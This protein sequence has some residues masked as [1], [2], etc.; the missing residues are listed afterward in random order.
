M[1]KQ[2]SFGRYYEVGKA[3]NVVTRKTI[4]DMYLSG[5][6][7]CAF[8]SKHCA[9]S[10]NT[11]R[12]VIDKYQLDGS[13]SPVKYQHG[14]TRLKSSEDIVQAI[15]YYKFRKPSIYG[16]EI[17]STL[18]S[19]GVTTNDRLPSLSTI[20]KILRNDCQMSHKK[21][22]VCAKEA[23]SAENQRRFDEYINTIS[24]INPYSL[25]F[26]D[27]SSVIKTTG[28][29]LYGHAT[30]G[31]K[32]IEV[33]KYASNATHTVNLLHGPFGIDYFN[34]LDG[35]SNG[36]HLVD[37]FYA[38]QELDRFG[39]YCLRPGDTVVMDN[40]G[41]HHG[42]FAENTLRFI[43]GHRHIDLL[44][45]PPYHP[46]LNTCEVCFKVM[47]DYLRKHTTYARE[48]TEMAI[49]DGLGQ[50]SASKSISIFRGCGY[51]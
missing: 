42:R 12:N 40:C 2:N 24:A 43:L 48:L 5:N 35:P 26:F 38:L 41:F 25:H 50:V 17:Q 20:S 16:K 19:D 4:L 1:I 47:K 44:Y 27:E 32:A 37:F 28:N 34:V 45:Q 23:L 46:D 11:V 21:L 15:R 18:L 14:A 9:V 33:Q 6:H 8:I 10:H 3:T 29:R 22:K 49:C 7:T 31:E 39:N 30:V 36:F 13:V 51:L